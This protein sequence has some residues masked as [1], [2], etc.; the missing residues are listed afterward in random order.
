MKETNI[1]EFDLCPG[2]SQVIIA[3]QPLTV[4]IFVNLQ[5]P[6]HPLACENIQGTRAGDLRE[7]SIGPYLSFCSGTRLL[8]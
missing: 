1:P 2:H 5:K 7:V 6:D 3:V 4:D 8:I